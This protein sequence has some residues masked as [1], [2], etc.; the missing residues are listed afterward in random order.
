MEKFLEYLQDAEKII[1]TVDHIV[2]VTFPLLKDK[3]LLLKIILETKTA[4][5]LCIN[6]V[7][8]HEYIYKRIN[9]YKNAETNFRI[10]IEKCA[11]RYKI[12]KNEI[13]L[14]L[15]LF[16]LA[17]KHKQSSMEFIK[18]EKIVILSE[19]MKTEAISIEKIKKFLDLAK[20]ILKKIK[21]VYSR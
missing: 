12:T 19:N 1:K 10:F 6:S 15:E 20:N 17:E 18:G 9:L 3:N 21:D 13:G 8:Q 2:Y 14:I 7:L 4:V 5:L 16:N 11:P